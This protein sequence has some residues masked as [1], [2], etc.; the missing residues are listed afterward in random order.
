MVRLL[1]F[2]RRALSH[3][4]RSPVVAG[5]TVGTVAVVFLIMGVFALVGHNLE[6][7]TQRV[8]SGLKLSVFLL[9]DC[10]VEQREDVR[11]LLEASA[12]VERVRFVDREEAAGRFRQRFG[13]Q[14][15]VLDELDGSPLPESFEVTFAPAGQNPRSI[16]ELAQRVVNS[17]GVEEVQYGQAWLDRFF[18][19]VQ[20]V[21][22]L[23]LAVGA[24]IFL[25]A[26]LI[27]ANTIRLSV[28]ARR[29]D[30]HILKLVGATDGF[31]KVP[32]Y[33]E[34]VLLGLLGASLGIALTWLA[35]A[36]LVPE[37]LVPG[38]LEESRFTVS[39]LPFEMVV[40][41]AGAG[42]FLGVLG[43]MSSLWRHLKI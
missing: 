15:D 10:S 16:G 1:Y 43:T 26:L 34:G 6:L 3:I 17:P 27:V 13:R 11:K 14:A 2:L 23:G 7:L 9:D 4:G 18:Q 31:I 28:Y 38:W 22:L 19:F 24:L 29:E 35:F 20:T 37:I 39:F 30:I 33:I 5:V 12:G 32:F 41:M 21:R 40:W 8:G 25:A 36:L 42:A